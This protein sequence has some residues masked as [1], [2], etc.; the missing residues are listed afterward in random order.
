MARKF[1]CTPDYP[2][3]ETEYGKLKGFELD[4]IFTFY[5][6]DYAKARRFHMP[7]P[8]EKW[9]GIKTA[10]DYGMTCP[11]MG[12]PVPS[13]ELLMPHRFWPEGE[14]CLNLNVW[15]PSIDKNAQKPVL[16][17]FHGG[18]YFNGSSVEQ[19]AYEGDAMAAWGDVVVVTINHRLNILGYLDLSAYGE[20]Y[21]NSVNAGIADLVAAL[22][23]VHNN[24]RNFGGDP[25]KV[26]IFGQSGGGGKVVNMLQTPAA[27][28][29]Y[30]R[31]VLMSGGAGH[32]KYG[33][34]VDMKQFVDAMM[35]DLKITDIHELEIVPYRVLERAYNRTCIKL[36]TVIGWAPK[37][38][39]WYLGHPAEVGFREYARTIPTMV[40]SVISEFGARGGKKDP[41]EYFG[42]DGEAAAAAFRKAYPD[43]DPGWAYSVAD[44][45]G[46]VN[47]MNLRAEADC[48][49]PAYC[50]LMSLTFDVEGGLPAW[51]CADIPYMFHNSYRC[52]YANVDGVSDKLEDDMA[53]ALIAFARNGDP[54]H[55]GMAEWKPWTRDCHAT[56]VFD[57]KSECK[58]DYD[59]EFQTYVKKHM[60]PR[61]PRPIPKSEE[62]EGRLWRY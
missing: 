28:G 50:Y 57:R 13:G 8:I 30:Q 27:D 40:S 2:V 48:S 21:H 26:L 20:E 41:G 12:T 59:D 31:A 4:G 15:T 7:E 22:Q 10:T 6:I 43:T 55:E 34:D 45:S 61:M 9:E 46:I 37:A 44:R 56:M 23:W 47:F 51:H 39:D 36:Q 42:E 53:G 11:T 33:Q 29:L 58:V 35:D 49:A 5:G 3:V 25:E 1:V 38:N 60:P 32:M 62:S 16:V 54:N 19:V 52:A 14:D 18:G 24:I 17:W